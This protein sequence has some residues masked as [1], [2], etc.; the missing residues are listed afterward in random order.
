MIKKVIENT[1]KHDEQ[2]S[3]TPREYPMYIFL[4]LTMKKT[5]CKEENHF[6]IQ[7][8]I[9]KTFNSKDRCNRLHRENGFTLTLALVHLQYCSFF[10]ISQIRL[11]GTHPPALRNSLPLRK[12]PMLNDKGLLSFLILL[13]THTHISV[14]SKCINFACFN[15]TGMDPIVCVL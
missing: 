2:R 9:V 8:S 5:F 15:F 4:S 14:S 7:I 11:L 12:W 13:R 10:L 6:A 3:I 1:Q